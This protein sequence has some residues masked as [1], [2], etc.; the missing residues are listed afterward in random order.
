MSR[1]SSFTQAIADEICFRIIDGKSLRSICADEHMPSIPTVFSWLSKGA[2]GDERYVNFLNQYTRARDLQG[3]TYAD[4]IIA[5]SDEADKE[6]AHAIRV[7][8]DARKWVASKLKPKKYADKIDVGV[9]G[10][11]NIT[12]KDSFSDKS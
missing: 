5:I 6:N 8:V 11:V 7:R 4:E 2:Q 1:P 10:D 9:S 3:D 12:V